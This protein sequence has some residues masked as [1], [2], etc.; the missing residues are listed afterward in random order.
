MATGVFGNMPTSTNGA[1]PLQFLYSTIVSA[2][3]CFHTRNNKACV[4]IIFCFYSCHKRSRCRNAVC[5]DFIQPKLQNKIAFLNCR[6]EMGSF[7]RNSVKLRSG[8]E[9][10]YVACFIISSFVR[11]TFDCKC[12]S[13][14]NHQLRFSTPCLQFFLSA[15]IILAV[16]LLNSESGPIHCMLSFVLY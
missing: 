5:I 3:E 6:K 15:P 13:S 1:D 8:K 12:M 10:S 16:L 14:I 2:V 7:Q 11:W 4:K 9:K